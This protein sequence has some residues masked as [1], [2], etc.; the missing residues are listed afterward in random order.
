MATVCI[1]RANY[2]QVNIDSLLTPLGG[3][4]AFVAEGDRVLLKMNLLSARGPDRAVTTHPA[5]VGAVAK[6][7]V[8]AGGTPF[9]GDSPSGTYNPKALRKAY[10]HSGIADLAE[11]ESIR[12]NDDTRSIKMS[13][14]E[15]KRLKSSA[16]CRF[17]QE[18]DKIIALPKLKTHSFQ[19]MTLACKIMYGLVPG[20]TK[21]TYHARFPSRGAFADM[22]LDLLTGIKPDLYIMDG[23]V[24]MEGQ[25]PASG[26][27]IRLG[28]V[29]AAADP[30]AMDI[31]VCDALGIEPVGIPVLRRAKVRKRWPET[32][33]YPLL[34]PADVRRKDFRL[35]NTADHLVTGAHPPSKRPVITDKCVGCGDCAEIC[36]K[37]AI[38][39]ESE[40]AEV[41]YTACIRCYCC[42]EVCPENAVA[43]SSKVPK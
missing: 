17:I 24:A 39:V 6:A 9:I 11:T 16:V 1:E 27:P 22:L 38:G 5:I 4:Q 14:P 23:I 40:K 20:L 26:D 34:S 12:L 43:L 37:G 25:G 10:V 35:P 8:Q 21:G 32:I 18:A 31:A 42:H 3:M 33:G 28:L 36:P 7:V 13:F 2:S 30:V 29:M 15:G 41:D 19:F